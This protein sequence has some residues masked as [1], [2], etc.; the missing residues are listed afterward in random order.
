MELI[1]E[2][3]ELLRQRM[4]TGLSADPVETPPDPDD[5]GGAPH[6]TAR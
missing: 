1:A 6:G 4:L 2:G 5:P 3:F